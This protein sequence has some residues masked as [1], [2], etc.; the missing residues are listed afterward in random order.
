MA[1]KTVLVPVT[2]TSADLAALRCAFTV[3]RT[4]DAHVNALFVRSDPRDAIPMLGEGLSGALVEEITEAAR[5]RADDEAH[6]ARRGFDEVVAE[7][8]VP[9]VQRAD[10]VTRFSVGWSDITGRTEDVV[11]QTGRLS[12]V[13]VFA[14][15][16]ADSTSPAFVTLQTALMSAG[17]PLLL[18]PAKS[19]PAIGS[20]IALAWNGQ[21]E[22]ARAVFGAM[23]FVRKAKA[24]H[25]LTVATMRTKGSAAEQLSD[26]LAWHG[27]ATEVHELNAQSEPV[28]ALILRQSAV[29][30]ANL[31]VMGGYGHSRVRELI[32]GGVTRYV[33]TNT[34]M[35]VLMSH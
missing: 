15:A 35:P 24:V 23:P 9:I 32:L 31:L 4:H 2:G 30:G 12:D 6:A 7:F 29:V 25:I 21:A 17:R 18:A 13:L 11:V 8:D 26:Y 10:G 19:W 1:I 28:G 22:S 16:A 33:L 3:G 34:A 27:I 20:T 5:V 14:H